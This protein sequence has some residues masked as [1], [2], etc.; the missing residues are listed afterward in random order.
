MPTKPVLHRVIT[1]VDNDRSG[2]SASR[3]LFGKLASTLILKTIYTTFI[4]ILDA[5]TLLF[6]KKLL[7]E[8]NEARTER[9]IT[10]MLSPAQL[11]IQPQ[12]GRTVA[13]FQ[14]EDQP[15]R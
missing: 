13:I 15:F 11:P 3:R 5:L 9:A 1:S 4:S 6:S 2:A 10:E 14:Q 8:R 12:R 7:D